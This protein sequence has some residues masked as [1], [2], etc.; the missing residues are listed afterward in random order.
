MYY[1]AASCISVSLG[2]FCFL[3]KVIKKLPK[4][5][6]FLSPENKKRFEDMFKTKNF[7]NDID[8]KMEEENNYKHPLRVRDMVLQVG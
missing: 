8:F 3:K 6:R 5:I 4:L 7:I 1:L 2:V